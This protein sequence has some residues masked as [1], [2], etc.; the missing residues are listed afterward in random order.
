MI[1]RAETARRRPPLN[2]TTPL[3]VLHIAPTVSVSDGISL[4][5]VAMLRALDARNDVNAALLTGHYRGLPLNPAISRRFADS[6]RIVPVLQPL[7]GRLGYTIAYPARFGSE[8]DSMAASSDVVHIHG[9]WLYPTLLGC[10]VLRRLGR[11]YVIS[12]HGSLMFEAMRRSRLKK[13]L[14]LA[15]GERTNILSAA[16][17]V[18]TSQ[19]ELEQFRAVDIPAPAVVI[20]LA[21]D[22][23]ATD[24]FSRA[25]MPLETFLRRDERTVLCVSRFHP[26]KRL[27]ELV[28]VFADVARE[29]PKWRLR[30][31]GPDD[32]PGY[33]SL[34]R[35][36]AVRSVFPDQ[37]SI[38]PAL[39]GQELWRT[40]RDA[41]LFVLPSTFE[42]FGLVIAEA[43]AAGV[44][45]IATNGAPWPQLRS[46]RCGWWIDPAIES[47][48]RAL[49]E[50]MSIQPEE[51]WHMGQ[52]GSRVIEADYSSTALGTRLTVLYRRVCG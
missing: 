51:R 42:N 6:T 2:P 38:E 15:L 10:R 18:T 44:P 22:A 50:A 46:H 29:F 11:P 43:L 14:A 33:R 5:V 20:P 34:V 8:L 3:R 12:P 16:A 13:K 32:F 40:Y 45:V 7:G 37:I 4:A 49:H 19:S 25:R 28:E 31:V 35:Q 36:A 27:V 52:S 1:T 21:V 41:D 47:L 26:R 9:L 48:R 23:D 30:I 39:A 24:F 17:I